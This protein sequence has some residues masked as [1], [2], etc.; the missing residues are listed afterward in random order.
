MEKQLVT[1]PSMEELQEL[2]DTCVGFMRHHNISFPEQIYDHDDIMCEAPCLV[3]RIADVT[4][5]IP[6]ED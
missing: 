6:F 5:Y 3:E 4:G 2:W 1:N